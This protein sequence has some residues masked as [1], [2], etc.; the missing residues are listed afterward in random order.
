MNFFIVYDRFTASLE[1]K[2]WSNSVTKRDAEKTNIKGF[3]R[4][5]LRLEV[6]LF[7][8]IVV[9]SGFTKK[10]ILNQL[11]FIGLSSDEVLPFQNIDH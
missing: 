9:I 3:K 1:N 5:I 11:Q 7:W 2:Y 10:P 6:R 8:A 4:Q